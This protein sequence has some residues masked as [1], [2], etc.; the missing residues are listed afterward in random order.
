MRPQCGR[1]ITSTRPSL[2]L[3]TPVTRSL[4]AFP[5]WSAALTSRTLLPVLSKTSSPFLLPHL[6]RV[7]LSQRLAS[8]KRSRIRYLASL[9]HHGRAKTSRRLR[10][11]AAGRTG[12][13]RPRRPLVLAPVTWLRPH[14]PLAALVRS[15]RRLW[16]Y[17]RPQLRRGNVLPTSDSRRPPCRPLTARPHGRPMYPAVKARSVHAIKCAQ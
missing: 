8:L 17:G 5:A 1:T 16:P 11:C 3:K 13:P 6:A 15:I 14:R 7:H 4:Y 12:S 9:R 2:S 10:C